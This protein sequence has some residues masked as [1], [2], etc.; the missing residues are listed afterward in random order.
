MRTQL[1]DILDIAD[2]VQ[3]RAWAAAPWNRS[4]VITV[5]AEPNVRYQLV[6]Y[7]QPHDPPSIPRAEAELGAKISAC[8][9][10]E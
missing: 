10:P 5:G 8:A 9:W 6:V 3:I 1:Y 7:D 4:L 2:L